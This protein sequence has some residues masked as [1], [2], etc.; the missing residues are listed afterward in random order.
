MK[1]VFTR[2]FFFG[3]SFFTLLN[4]LNILKIPL[5]FPWIVLFLIGFL[6]WSFW[7]L[8]YKKKFD[9]PA[10]MA[11]FFIF[12]IY[13]DTIGNVFDFY[14]KVNWFDRTTHF[15]G[16]ITAGMFSFFLLNHFNKKNNW[17][18]SFKE[19]MVIFSSLALSFLVF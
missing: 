9:S 6:G 10:I 3:I 5:H 1:F 2:I 12:N 11:G 14:H 7:E 17:K 8:I 15:I 16:G 18:L 13:T 4:S 19:M